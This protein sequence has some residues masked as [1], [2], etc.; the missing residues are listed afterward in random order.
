MN[1]SMSVQRELGTKVEK[2]LEKVHHEMGLRGN[3]VCLVNYLLGSHML[4]VTKSEVTRLF[5]EFDEFS[6]S[7]RRPLFSAELGFDKHD[8]VVMVPSTELFIHDIVKC[9]KQMLNYILNAAKI[10][11]FEGA[12]KD[13]EKYGH[14][15]IE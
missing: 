14:H 6:D 8:R 15:L 10:I 11:D 3:F 5:T 1:K 13:H 2:E 4:E 7:R 9:I 12:I